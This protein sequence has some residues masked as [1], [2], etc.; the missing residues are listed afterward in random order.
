[1]NSWKWLCTGFPYV[2][3]QNDWHA[4]IPR[5]PSLTS[6]I[7]ALMPA[8]NCRASTLS[9]PAAAAGAAAVGVVAAGAAAVGVATASGMSMSPASAANAA[10]AASVGAGPSDKLS[11]ADGVDDSCWRRDAGVPAATALC[12]TRTTLPWPPPAADN[13]L[14]TLA[15]RAVPPNQLKVGGINKKKNAIADAIGSYCFLSTFLLHHLLTSLLIKFQ[16]SFKFGDYLT[17]FLNNNLLQYEAH[18]IA[19]TDKI[20]KYSNL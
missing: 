20:N 4:R 14:A 15:G 7:S 11:V 12:G 13:N 17:G 5:L 18:N 6:S 3:V 1:M 8:S 9:K 10:N 16:N 2:F 19:Q